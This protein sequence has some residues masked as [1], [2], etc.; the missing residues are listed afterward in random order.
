MRSRADMF[1]GSLHP[2][3]ECELPQHLSWCQAL[4][5][6]VVVCLTARCSEIPTEFYYELLLPITKLNNF[7]IF[8][9]REGNAVPIGGLSI[10]A[11]WGGQDSQAQLP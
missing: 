3:C 2:D 6:T 4:R 8:G 1:V 10:P 9:G 5:A 7:F 11:N